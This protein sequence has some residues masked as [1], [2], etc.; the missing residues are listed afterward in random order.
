MSSPNLIDVKGLKKSYQNKQVIHG[1]DF[2]VSPGEILCLLGPN[3]AGKSTTINILT[4]ALRYSAGEIR[5]RGQS[6][7]QDLQTYK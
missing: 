2:Y 4:G 5:W 6:I 3:G 7:D 1:I